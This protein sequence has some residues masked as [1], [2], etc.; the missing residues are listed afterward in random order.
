MEQ[1]KSLSFFEVAVFSPL[2]IAL[3][4]NCVKS[5]HSI[6]VLLLEKHQMAIRMMR[7][8]LILGGWRTVPELDAMVSVD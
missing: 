6:E 8:L 4:V 5:P 3:L 2:E 1:G 7:V